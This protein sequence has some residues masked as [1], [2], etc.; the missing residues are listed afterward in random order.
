LDISKYAKSFSILPE[1]KM[2]ANM[3]YYTK[4]G[5]FKSKNNKFLSLDGANITSSAITETGSPNEEF[6]VEYSNSDFKAHFGSFADDMGQPTQISLKCGAVKKLLPYNGFYPQQRTLQL[7]SQLSQSVAPFISGYKWTTGSATDPAQPKSGSLAVQSLLQPYFA[8]GIMYNTIKSGIAVDWAAHTSSAPNLLTSSGGE[9]FGFDNCSNTAYINSGSDYRIPFESIMDPLGG[10]FIPISSSVNDDRLYLQNP[11]FQQFNAPFAEL[12]GSGLKYPYVNIRDA[13]RAA[14]QKEGSDYELYKLASNNFFAEVPNFFLNNGESGKL[15]SITSDVLEKDVTLESGSVYFMDIALYKDE[16]LVM[17]E[18]YANGSRQINAGNVVGAT[19]NTFKILTQSNVPQ[20]PLFPGDIY[21][22]YNGRFFGPPVRAHVSGSTD[23]DANPY[24]AYREKWGIND[25]Y[26]TDPGFAPYT[27][28]YF[29]GKS[30]ATIRY[31]ADAEDEIRGGFSFD[32][33][34]NKCLRGV[35]D[36]GLYYYNPELD[37]AF[38]KLGSSNPINNGTGIY[39][40]ERSPADADRMNISASVELFGILPVPEV[41]LDDNNNLS[42]EVSTFTAGSNKLLIC[43]KMETPVLNFVNQPVSSQRWLDT[44]KVGSA[45]ATQAGFVS[46]A[47][48]LWGGYGEIPTSSSISFAV[49]KTKLDPK[50]DNPLPNN[51]LNSL[52]DVLFNGKEKQ[53]RVGEI[54]QQKIISEAIVAIPFVQNSYSSRSKFATTVS[55]MDNKNFFK[56][57]KTVFNKFK[58]HYIKNRTNPDKVLLQDGQ[59]IQVMIE[60]MSQY[61]MPPQLDFLNNTEITP[62]ASYIFEFKA[63]LD[64][65]DLA[66]IWQGLMPKISTTAEIPNLE[67]DKDNFGLPSNEF[68]HQTGKNEFYGGKELPC[69]VRWMVF[70]VKK[71]ANYDYNS[72]RPDFNTST[73]VPN[74][75]TVKNGALLKQPY[76]YNWPYDYFSLVEL[77]QL[78]VEDGF[79][80]SPGSGSVGAGTTPR[81]NFLG[82]GS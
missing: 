49:E 63:K 7:A 21:R 9:G 5:G 70:K 68:T 66:D 14:A 16:N 62:F 1:F 8:P 72:I 32:K 29:Y 36:S 3:P 37:Q 17:I 57:N 58:N 52:V 19:S 2:S 65:Q 82:G 76:S 47:K 18:D 42:Q 78:E 73:L 31:V 23:Q 71:R 24:G 53:E 13:D 15:K 39:S 56:I 61:V 69:D 46:T 43:P 35:Q 40:S 50:R 11:S 20:E 6:F 67:V 10:N 45:G 27:P 51:K 77:A 55:I 28:P 34:K 59:S 48:G 80:L 74:D 75:R 64:Q 38:N 33:M 26:I 22:S 12:A 79:T 25:N 60:R 41:R 30:I 54:K 81:F 44:S 4:S